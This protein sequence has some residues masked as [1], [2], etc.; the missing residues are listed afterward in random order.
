MAPVEN[1]ELYLVKA[2]GT[3]N[4]RQ[5]V[6]SHF[7]ACNDGRAGRIARGSDRRWLTEM[8]WTTQGAGFK[9]KGKKVLGT[10]KK[11]LS[12]LGGL[13]PRVW[14]RGELKKSKEACW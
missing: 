3:G 6:G 12:R 10:G 14:Y 11:N 1:Y 9:K 5:D 4:E 13:R 2:V 8:V 7:C